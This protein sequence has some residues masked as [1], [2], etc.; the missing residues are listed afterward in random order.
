M[1]LAHLTLGELK[2]LFCQR[3]H[4]LYLLILTSLILIVGVIMSSMLHV[5]DDV[6]WREHLIQEFIEEQEKPQMEVQGLYYSPDVKYKEY[7]L[8][9][10]L[11]PYYWNAWR[12]VS[13]VTTN[14]LDIFISLFA[15]LVACSMVSKEFSWGTMKVLAVRPFKRW[16]ILISKYIA[17]LIYTV[18]LMGVYAMMSYLIGGFL[19]DFGGHDYPLV[20]KD[21]SGSFYEIA[22]IQS[23]LEVLVLRFLPIFV[24]VTIAFMLSTIVRNQA[25]ALGISIFTL[26]GG[27][28]LGGAPFLA[29]YPWYKLTLFPHLNLVA[30][31]NA[32]AGVALQDI[33]ILF[34]VIALLVYLLLLLSI[35]ILAFT[36]QDIKA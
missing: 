13:S 20:R 18:L 35:S 25:I 26:F 22:V 7:Y 30:Y 21:L 19:F 23:A 31:I 27:S 6:N 14:G 29:K 12:F 24:L 3:R 32:D 1:W 28:I 34:S 8:E 33:S 36:R 4:L 5:T 10:D 16:K 15:I 9:H 17:T 2:K 11:N